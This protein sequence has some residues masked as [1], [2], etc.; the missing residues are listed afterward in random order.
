LPAQN[1]DREIITLLKK[2]KIILTGWRLRNIADSATAILCI[3][4]LGRCSSQFLMR[5]LLLWMIRKK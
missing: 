5:E 2:R 3:V 1:A 4:K